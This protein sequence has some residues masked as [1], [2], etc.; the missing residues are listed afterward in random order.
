MNGVARS[1]IGTDGATADPVVPPTVPAAAAKFD[2]GRLAIQALPISAVSFSEEPM[3]AWGRLLAYGAL[4]AVLW[5]KHRT[6][7]YAAMG[8]TGLSLVTSLSA[9][10][11]KK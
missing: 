7:A 4:S 1:Y 2:F 3:I 5:N 10:A 6:M 8:A 11:L 9:S